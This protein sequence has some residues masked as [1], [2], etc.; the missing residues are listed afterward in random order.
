M[1][2]YRWVLLLF[3][4]NTPLYAIVLESNQTNTTHETT[5]TETMP[6]PQSASS[7]LLTSEQSNAL[8]KQAQTLNPEQLQAIAKS[9]QSPQQH[10]TK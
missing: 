9:F 4:F 5:P 7:P 3:L 1:R 2:V 10:Q 6:P 8:L